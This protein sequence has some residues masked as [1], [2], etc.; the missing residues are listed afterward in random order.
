MRKTATFL[1]L[2]ALVAC[3]APVRAQDEE[4]KAPLPHE[5]VLSA[6]PLLL[7]HKWFNVDY[8]RRIAPALTLGA[9]A[10][11]MTGFNIGTA[12][13]HVRFY[14]GR[15]ALSGFHIGVHTGVGYE[16]RHR[17]IPGVGAEIGYAWLFGANRDVGLSLGIGS[18]RMFGADGAF[19]FP[20]LRVFN[21]GFAF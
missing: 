6:S 9:S 18:T 13:F 8:E 11:H 5:Q 3:A 16:L 10:L 7:V 17:S 2:I 21:V 14:P 20:N 12:M 19:N 15:A 4:T 1:G